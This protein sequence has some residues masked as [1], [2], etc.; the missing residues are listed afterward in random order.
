MQLARGWIQKRAAIDGEKIALQDIASKRQWTYTELV[1]E[2]SKWQQLF[3]QQGVQSGDRIAL[4]AFNRIDYFSVLFACEASGIIF[5]P[6]NWR[7]S[8]DEWQQL[9]EDC[10]PTL[11]LYDEAFAP[12]IDAL[13]QVTCIPFVTPAIAPKRLILQP[14]ASC[15]QLIYTGGTTGKSKGVMLSY[16]AV[17]A[18]AM[19]T[20][21]SWGLHANDCTV[22]YM[23]LFHTGGLNAL[24]LP[25]LLAGGTVVIGHKFQPEEASQALESYKATIALFVPTMYQA[26]F[27]TFHFQHATFSSMRVFLSGGAPCP[28]TVYDQFAKKNLAFKEGY[29][30]SEAGPNNFVI[31]PEIA[32]QKQGAVGQPMLLNECKIRRIDGAHC[33]P[34]EVGEL[35]VK[36]PHVFSGYWQNEAATKEALQDGWLKT[37]DLARMD[38]DGDVFIVGRAKDMIICGG[39]NIYPQEIEACIAALSFVQE[40]AVVGMPD[41]YWGEVVTA[42]VVTTYPSREVEKQIR[43]HCEQMLSKYKVPKKIIFI[44][45]LPTTAVG[46]VDKKALVQ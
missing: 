18:N 32:R 24:S 23:P 22:N 28:K 25:V 7:L 39:E 31:S 36:G 16:E 30:L 33:L 45:K 35:Y 27:E 6:F 21:T 10:T 43:L 8:N 41:A 9:I 13:H 44:D 17:N 4:L 40:V 15:W 38:E 37:G 34:E 26:M 29:G 1:Q 11:L 12:Y 3:A 2:A 20:V 19:N 46:K 5:V 42:Y 14:A